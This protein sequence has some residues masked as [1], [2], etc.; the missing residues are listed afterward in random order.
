MDMNVQAFRL[1]QEATQESSVDKKRKRAAA[2]KGGLAG[3][4]AR[5][6][7]MTDSRR[8]EI[9][10]AGSSARWSHKAPELA[11]REEER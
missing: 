4:R 10:L 5:A 9:A 8:R 7:A 6:D 1:V 3:G 11:T 2:R